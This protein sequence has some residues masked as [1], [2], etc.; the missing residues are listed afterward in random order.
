M[1]RLSVGPVLETRQEIVGKAEQ[2][3]FAPTPTTHAAL[4]PKIQD[5]VEVDVQKEGRQNR[6]LWRTELCRLKQA[7]LHHT[8]F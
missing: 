5:K 8:S 4:E 2:I 1:K 3:G 6:A 7:V